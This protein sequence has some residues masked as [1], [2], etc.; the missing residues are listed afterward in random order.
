M[1]TNNHLVKKHNI[2]LEEFRNT[3]KGYPTE[4][5]YLQKVRVDVGLAIGSKESVKSFRTYC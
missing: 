1:I 2:T 3:Y 5:E 4:S